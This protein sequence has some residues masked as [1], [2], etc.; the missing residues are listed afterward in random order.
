MKDIEVIKLSHSIR[1]ISDK[2]WTLLLHV[3][4]RKVRIK[5]FNHNPPVGQIRE[6]LTIAKTC[7]DIANEY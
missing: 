6:I 2:K 4:H 3:G 5:D 1:K 7:F